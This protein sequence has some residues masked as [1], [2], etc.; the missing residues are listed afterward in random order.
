[1]QGHHPSPSFGSQSQSPQ[2]LAPA[3]TRPK[4][5]VAIPLG[6]ISAGSQ[7]VMSDSKSAP[8]LQSIPNETLSRD[9]ITRTPSPTP[10]EAEALEQK[11]TIGL[12]NKKKMGN[13]AKNWW[14]YVVILIV[15]AA[16]ALFVIFRDDILRGL[17][18]AAHWL[19]DTPGGWVIPIVILI[20]LSFPPLFG[21]E[22]V[23]M[24]CGLVWGLGIGFGIVAAGTL[25]GELA[26]F[27]VFRFFSK[28]S[29]KFERRISYACLVRVVQDGGFWI[30]LMIRYSWI[31]AHLTTTIF[32]FC[33]MSSLVFLAAAILSL[34]KQLVTVF[35]GVS[36]G[37]NTGNKTNKKITIPVV[38][39]GV[40]VGIVAF[41]FVNYRI[42][43]VKDQVIYER[44]K[45]RCVND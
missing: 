35:L 6:S 26:N 28:R 36:F 7:Q 27:Y 13:P 37:D 22:I 5:L 43:K 41:R 16:I 45:E 38:V 40:V 25:L 19:H 44:R 33:E 18:P 21:H 12:V 30:A 14:I 15:V 42:N 39:V 4:N 8:S 24:L 23:I 29:K 11:I 9:L 32:A 20:V 31:P 17:E 10:S 1:M 34:P 2:L 3:P